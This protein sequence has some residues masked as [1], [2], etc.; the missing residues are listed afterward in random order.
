M[1]ELFDRV[2]QQVDRIGDINARPAGI[3]IFFDERREDIEFVTLFGPGG[4][5]PELFNLPESRGVIVVVS[6]G[7]NFHRLFP[8]NIETVKAS[9]RSYS[10]CVQT[11]L[12]NA[13]RLRGGKQKTAGK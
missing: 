7:A 10:T 4:S 1:S 11:N 3:L 2:I 12:I 8:Q 13:M 5:T 6:N 9:I